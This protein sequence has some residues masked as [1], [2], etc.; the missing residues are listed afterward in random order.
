MRAIRAAVDGL[1]E[2]AGLTT[3]PLQGASPHTAPPTPAHTDRL[4]A[5]AELR[6]PPALFTVPGDASAGDIDF[7]HPGPHFAEGSLPFLRQ[8]VAHPQGSTP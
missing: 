8:A 6:C 1:S 4:H 3:A 2:P 7:P 5:R